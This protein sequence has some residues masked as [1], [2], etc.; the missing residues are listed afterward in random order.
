MSNGWLPLLQMYYGPEF[1]GHTLD[2]W[3]YGRGIAL[4][5][6]DPGKPVQNCMIESFNGKLRDE[7]LSAHWFISLADARQIIEAWRRD[8]NEAR[9]HTSLGGLTPL[10]FVRSFNTKNEPLNPTTGTL[11]VV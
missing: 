7:C 4:R 3:A 9:P 8:Y 11:P 1:A 2:A 5:F 10:E 6:I